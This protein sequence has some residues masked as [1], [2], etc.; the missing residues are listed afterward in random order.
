M[1]RDIFNV[2]D[3][4]PI[5]VNEPSYCVLK[6]PYIGKPSIMFKK[7][8]IKAFKVFFGIEMRAVYNTCQLGSFFSLKSGVP[9]ALKSN[10]VYKFTCRLDADTFYIGKTIRSLATRAKE[11]LRPT[12]SMRDTAVTTHVRTCEPCQSATIN[13]FKV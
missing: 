12:E 6:I 3:E 2:D 13:D 11:H 4:P 7:D 9:L 10:V 8:L 1:P 5:N